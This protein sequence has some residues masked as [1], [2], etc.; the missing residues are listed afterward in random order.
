MVPSRY[1][2]V[3][4]PRLRPLQS[5]GNLRERLGAHL[6]IHLRREQKLGT[7]VLSRDAGDDVRDGWQ[8]AAK[9]KP[10]DLVK[11]GSP[12]RRN[13]NNDPTAWVDR[14]AF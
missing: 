1:V 4:D 13:K 14:I 9:I 2:N 12:R 8:R 11:S 10:L 3:V 7:L 6:L 5:V